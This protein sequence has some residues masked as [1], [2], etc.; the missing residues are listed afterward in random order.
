MG[1]I[2]SCSGLKIYHFL[3]YYNCILRDRAIEHNGAVVNAEGKVL[4]VMRQN[5]GLLSEKKSM[6]HVLYKGRAAIRILFLYS[7]RASSRA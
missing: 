4:T 1:S 7:K 2:T 5:V 6:S 3:L